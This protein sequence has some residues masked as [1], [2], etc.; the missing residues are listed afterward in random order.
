MI[1]NNEMTLTFKSLSE[2][3]SFAR[4]CVASFCMP[5][6]PS[7]D[8]INDLKTAV[9]E[10]VTNCVVHGYPNSMGDITIKVKIIDASVY[11]TVRDFGVGIENISQA[12]EPFYTTK[13]ESERSG[14]GFTVM[15]SFMDNVEV[16]STPGTGTTVVLSKKIGEVASAV[17][18]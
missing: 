2:N 5:L 9:S 4:A 6:S 16:F 11:I 7:L 8:E 17:G 15:E 13:P 14:M 1:Y 12:K 3:E 18:G 10:A